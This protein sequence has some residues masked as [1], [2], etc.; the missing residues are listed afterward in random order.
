LVDQAGGVMIFVSLLVG[1]LLLAG[2]ALWGLLGM[3]LLREISLLEFIAYATG[4]AVL[5]GVAILSVGTPLMWGA[6]LMALTVGVGFTRV[7]K[8]HN[9]RMIRRLE[10]KDIQDYTARTRKRPEI[11]YP[12]RKLAEIAASRGQLDKAVQWYREYLERAEDTTAQRRM[13]RIVERIDEGEQ[14]K[15]VCAECRQTNPADR[16]YCGTCGAVLPGK[17]EIVE[18]LQ[19]RRGA[20]RVLM[21]SLGCVALGLIMAVTSFLPSFLCAVCFWV[22]SIAFVYFLYKR[23]LLF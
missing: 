17:W 3:L 6:G 7:R 19:G 14:Q 1:A 2:T 11:P 12:Y 4:F 10:D 18:Q 5:V 13:E 8:W 23:I 21:V 16:R 20:G 9:D 22:A 15:V